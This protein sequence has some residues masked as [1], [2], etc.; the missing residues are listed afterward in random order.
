MKRIT[1]LLLSIC[2]AFALMSTALAVE[3]V[4]AQKTYII[5]V[6][7]EKTELELR[8]LPRQPYLEGDV[9]MVPLRLNAEALGYEVGWNAETGAV[10]VDDNYIQKATLFN[11]S[12]QVSFEGRL[13]V[14]DMSRTAEVSAPAVIHDGYTYVP[15]EF[16]GEF[17]NDTIE[18]N[19]VI[20]I[21]TS[22]CELM[23]G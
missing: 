17:L 13:K 1:S 7:P 6:G 23:E 15:L 11:A 20:T 9:I 4:P 3:S 16:F 19:G 2:C 22:T 8:D 12:A 10:T 14:I 21:A 18:E 5:R